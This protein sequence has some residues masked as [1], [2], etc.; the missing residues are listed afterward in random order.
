MNQRIPFMLRPRPY[1]PDTFKGAL[2][3]IVCNG[4]G[5]GPLEHA[6]DSGFCHRKRRQYLRGDAYH[7]KRREDEHMAWLVE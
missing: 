7:A 1:D 4:C 2:V 6:P 3:Q 5:G